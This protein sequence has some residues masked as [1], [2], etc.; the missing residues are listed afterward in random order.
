MASASPP[1]IRDLISE[2]DLDQLIR[3]MASAEV[4]SAQGDCGPRTVR[5]AA[6][7]R[8]LDSRFRTFQQRYEDVV[9]KATQRDLKDPRR[10]QQIAAQLKADVLKEC[11]R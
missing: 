2:R 11:K 3:K 6:R 4:E 5:N 10:V 8:A 9:K 7:L 1:S